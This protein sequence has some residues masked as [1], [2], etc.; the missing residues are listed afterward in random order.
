MFSTKKKVIIC[1]VKTTANATTLDRTWTV[2]NA[3]AVICDKNLVGIQSQ[4]L[5]SLQNL[6]FNY[7]IEIDRMFYNEQ[8]YLYVDNSLFTIQ[9]VSP[10][11]Q[12]KDC[13]LNVMALDDLEIKTAIEGWINGNL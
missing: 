5:A 9:S 13:K 4:Q 1:D 3:R 11:K 12:P 6:T 2:F 7:S 8:K 10:A